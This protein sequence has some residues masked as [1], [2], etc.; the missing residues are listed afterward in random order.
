LADNPAHP[1]I[2]RLLH[3]TLG[4]FLFLENICY[5]LDEFN[6]SPG[7]LRIVDFKGGSE[8]DLAIPLRGI[9]DDRSYGVRPE[10]LTT[11]WIVT[12]SPVMTLSARSESFLSI[13]RR[14]PP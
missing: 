4:G 7:Q 13:T 6:D 2:R 12:L 9:G 8:N 5:P 1:G 11:G 14:Q 10:Q 3:S